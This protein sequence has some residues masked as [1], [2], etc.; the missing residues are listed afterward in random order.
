[1]K[2]HQHPKHHPRLDVQYAAET[3]PNSRKQALSGLFKILLGYFSVFF[4]LRAKR[5][6]GGEQLIKE[7]TQGE[8]G[9]KYM[10]DELQFFATLF[11][12][13]VKGDTFVRQPGAPAEI[14]T[15]EAMGVELDGN[16]DHDSG[17]SLNLNAT[18]QNTEITASAANEGN[19]AQ[20]QPG[21]QVRMTPSYEFEVG[22]MY[23]N[24]YATLTAV[25]DRFGNNENTVVLPGYEKVDFGVMVEPTDRLK[26]QLAVDNL[27]D[28]QGI[29]EGDPRNADAPNGRYILPR[30]V[31]FSI[32][33]A[34]Y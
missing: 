4:E 1:M 20:R 31:K 26:L 33:Y 23:A 19:E 9:Y 29:T 30:S 13:R 32:S 25:D 17:F 27:T 2:T 15:N 8:V 22:E 24:V 10:N 12:N 34:L 14:L 21:W 16:Y 3:K 28:E 6:V 11:A 7:V 5:R 18:V